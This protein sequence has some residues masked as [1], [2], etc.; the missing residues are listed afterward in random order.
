MFLLRLG[1]CGTAAAS[2]TVV[3][4]IEIGGGDRVIESN[5]TVVVEIE[6]G[7]CMTGD[8]LN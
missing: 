4:E 3:V 5:A 1:F 2:A 8:R 7:V 6:I